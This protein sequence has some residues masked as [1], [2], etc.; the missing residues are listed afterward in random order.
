VLGK[1]GRQQPR[2][3]SSLSRGFTRLPSVRSGVHHAF[4]LLVL[5]GYIRSPFVLSLPISELLALERG[6]RGLCS[7]PLLAQSVRLILVPAHLFLSL[8]TLRFYLFLLRIHSGIGLS[9][10]FV[11]VPDAGLGRSVSE[12]CL[13]WVSNSGVPLL[14]LLLCCLGVI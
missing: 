2:S 6:G 14:F 8:V 4:L 9:T 7:A 3:S 11:G 5:S 12:P 10:C 1:Q 13:R